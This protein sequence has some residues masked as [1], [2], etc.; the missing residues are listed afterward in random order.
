MYKAFFFR[1]PSELDFHVIERKIA[2][3]YSR[4]AHNKTTYTS[5]DGSSCFQMFVLRLCSTCC[6]SSLRGDPVEF[7]HLG[8]RTLDTFCNFLYNFA[9]LIFTGYGAA[10]AS[11]SETRTALKIWKSYAGNQCCKDSEHE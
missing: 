9:V 6:V 4:F 2:V 3:E 5:P 11:S 7:V 8:A 1:L 10:A